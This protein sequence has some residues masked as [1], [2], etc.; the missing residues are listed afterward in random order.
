MATTKEQVPIRHREVLADP[1]VQL[2]L[3]DPLAKRMLA[4]ANERF[5]LPNA[6]LIAFL[7]ATALIYGRALT[8]GGG[9][10]S[11]TWG[12]LLAYPGVLAYS[13]LV[14]IFD[15]HK[16]YEKDLVNHPGRVLQSGLITLRHLKVLGAV[17]IAL[18][19]LTSILEDG[20][21]G[22]V[23]LWWVILMG[24]T[25]LMLKEFFARE[26][27]EQRLVIYAVSHLVSL[28][29]A[30]IWMAQMGGRGHNLPASVIWFALAA[31][32]VGASFE[33]SRK[34]EAPEDERPT[35][36][37]YSKEL[38]VT[39]ASVAIATLVVA[40]AACAAAAMAATHEN[41]PIGYAGLVVAVL[42]GI[43]GAVRFGRAPTR[44]H[45]QLA[46]GMAATTIVL[47][48]VALMAQILAGRGIG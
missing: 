37:S 13:L 8:N 25:L 34:L 35:L 10:L 11:F 7:Y 30:V 32:F 1:G 48:L 3:Q 4:W 9:A 29:I 38:G 12:D 41:S 28:P 46:E 14:R 23:T 47:I 2:S 33:V 36:D 19:A 40:C 44:A 42:P 27:L 24:Y 43:F 22:R 18:M 39:G 45:T 31:G 21:I 6:V 15:E 5:P 20:G 26:W 16:D 17:C